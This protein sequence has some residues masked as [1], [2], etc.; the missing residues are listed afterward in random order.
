MARLTAPL[1]SLGAS[2]TIGKALVYASWKGIPYARVHVIP[3]NPKTVGQQEV[4]GVFATLNNMYKRMGIQARLPWENAARGLPLTARNIHIRENV[5]ALQGDVNMDDLV[6]S[7]ATGQAIIPINV[8]AV[9]GTNGR[10]ACF[11]E[12]PPAPVGYSLGYIVGVA[13]EDG[14]PS[15]ALSPRVFEA[16]DAAPPYAFDIYPL[17]DEDFQVGIFARWVRNSDG[18]GF[19]SE[20]VRFQVTVTGTP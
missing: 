11:A 18:K 5:A 16:S 17:L 9:D 6:M 8:T 7:I 4:R 20:A 15:P 1:L 2:G 19:C 13:V 14:D 12:A 10:I 3:A